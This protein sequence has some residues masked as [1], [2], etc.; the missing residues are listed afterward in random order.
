VP[1]HA[2]LFL[3]SSSVETSSSK[4]A[5]LVESF[6]LNET[7]ETRAKTWADLPSGHYAWPKVGI[8]QILLDRFASPQEEYCEDLTD[9][10][11]GTLPAAAGKL[12]YLK[13]LGVDGIALS[14]VVDN[15][16]GGY[17]GY[18][19][20]DLN[21]VNPKLGTGAD[22]A[23][24][25]FQAHTN[26][27]KVISDVVL[28]HAGSPLMKLEDISMLQP[29]GSVEDY[30]QDN[31]SLWTGADFSQSREKLERCSLFGMPDYNHEDPRVASGL[32]EWVRTHVDTYGFDGIRIDAAK[33]MPLSF[34]RHL[35]E[36]GAPVP[37][38]YEVPSSDLQEVA[39]YN[40]NDFSA[41]YNYPLYHAIHDVFVPGNA[42]KP[43]RNLEPLLTADQSSLLL[44][45]LDNNDIAR[46]AHLVGDEALYQNALVAVTMAAG[47][48]VLLYGS[49]QALE[50]RPDMKP[51]QEHDGYRLPLW[52]VGYQRSE[53]FKFLKSL[54]W[55]RKEFDGFHHS[56]PQIL[57][58]DHKVLAFERGNVQV[59][60]TSRG[61]SEHFESRVMWGNASRRIEERCNLL[62]L[63]KEMCMV[64]PATGFRQLDLHGGKPL[65]MVPRSIYEKYKAELKSAEKAARTP[66]ETSGTSR[67]VQASSETS[68]ALRPQ[69][70]ALKM[71][72]LRL[73]EWRNMPEVELELETMAR[74]SR[75]QRQ[76]DVVQMDCTGW[77]TNSEMPLHLDHWYPPLGVLPSQ[78]LQASVVD[79]CVVSDNVVAR[80][81]GTDYA[82]CNNDYSCSQ[83]LS[84]DMSSTTFRER[85]LLH[86]T[87]GQL[88]TGFYHTMVE[89]I[90]R[91]VEYLPALRQ[92][93]M[94]ILLTDSAEAK[95]LE[96]LMARLGVPSSSLVV[97]N[98]K[99]PICSKKLIFKVG[100][101]API[102]PSSFVDLRR[103][104]SLPRSSEGGHVVIL[105]RGSGSRSLQN[106]AEL[107]RALEGLGRQVLV[108]HAHD[109][110]LPETIEV[111]SKAELLVGNHG[112]NLVNMLYAPADAKVL[113]IV[114]QVPFPMVNS[115]YRTLAGALGFEYRTVGHHVSHADINFALKDTAAQAIGGYSV[116]IP[117]V[118]AAAASLLRA[119]TPEIKMKL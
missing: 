66:P 35:A 58:S 67:V 50:G 37:T 64:L 8:Y 13:E 20:K 105:S 86:I 46:F 6:E 78:S 75:P 11:G 83:H 69:A 33:H 43:M 39:A 22:L 63:E 2:A 96:P 27:M 118:K 15:M 23:Q 103:A 65:V 111:L 73:G 29:F 81:Q 109:G 28:N 38:F 61:S 113:E 119:K 36:D 56:P 117:K 95:A 16:P 12:G 48:P 17:H 74:F 91:F 60:L 9:Y 85:P 70:K 24:F 97:A 21:A 31:C 82:L 47:V 108:W 92:G 98:K 10:C 5:A 90:P 45:F 88:Y 114:P 62:S 89:M 79:G 3:N 32:M 76:E 34:L 84:P 94:D 80:R 57:F 1:C 100:V 26:D 101:S 116:D 68:R 104:L 7:A 110:N 4:T 44:N 99:S 25:I 51:G 19:P 107:A 14:P 41:V 71:L 18:W 53:T 54:L 93:E 106:E 55:L 77:P 42:R 72:D 112:A 30:H 102:S 115:Q 52:E 59:V 87:Y 49:E 40:T